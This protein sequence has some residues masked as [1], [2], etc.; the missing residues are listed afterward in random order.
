MKNC[1]SYWYYAVSFLSSLSRAL[2]VLLLCCNTEFCAASTKHTKPH[3]KR[4]TNQ[5]YYHSIHRSQNALFEPKMLMTMNCFSK[6]IARRKVFNFISKRDHCQ[7]FS[8]SQ[9]FDTPRAVFESA[10]NLSSSLIEWSCAIVRTTTPRCHQKL[11]SQEALH[12]STLAW[13]IYDHQIHKT[14]KIS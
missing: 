13:R 3:V 14:L 1:H 11:S 5:F 6:M 9:I 4:Q 10:Q 12:F 8:P 7:R 2:L